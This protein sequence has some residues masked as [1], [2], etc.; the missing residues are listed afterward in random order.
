MNAVL[1]SPCV[2]PM[3]IAKTLS[4]LTVVPVNLDL[5][6]TG[7]RALVRSKVYRISYLKKKIVF[8]IGASP[9]FFLGRGVPLFYFNVNKPQT[10][11]SPIYGWDARS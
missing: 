3:P 8:R 10:F 2:M 6:E 11:Y 1:L 5:L 9:G 7:K 4:A